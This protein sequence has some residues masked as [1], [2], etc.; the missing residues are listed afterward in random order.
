MLKNDVKIGVPP[1]KKNSIDQTNYII[2]ILTQKVISQVPFRRRSLFIEAGVFREQNL[3]AL[4]L[5]EKM[6]F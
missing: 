6:I 5:A 2:M 4:I 3:S 1:A